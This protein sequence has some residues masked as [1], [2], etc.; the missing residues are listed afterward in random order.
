M[1]G[2]YTITSM[3]YRYRFRDLI[4]CFLYYLH[5]PNKILSWV[6]NLGKKD[7]MY[8]VNNRKD[9]KRVLNI[10]DIQKFR[11]LR[12]MRNAETGWVHID[13]IYEEAFLLYNV[14]DKGNIVLLLIELLG[15]QLVIPKK[16]DGDIQQLTYWKLTSKYW[17]LY[18]IFKWS[19][20]IFTVII[21][22]IITA[23]ILNK[24]GALKPI[25]KVFIN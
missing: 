21:T 3:K 7:K 25:S 11:V 8:H 22:A 1:K 10:W 23:I 2:E 19:K 6:T 13:I 20:N 14:N 4:A 16:P 18:N 24:L 12:T 5:A 15:K 9:A 17:M